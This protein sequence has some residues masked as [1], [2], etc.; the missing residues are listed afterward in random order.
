MT[1]GY[2]Y[3]LGHRAHTHPRAPDSA[4]RLEALLAYLEERG[5]LEPLVHLPVEAIPWDWIAAVHSYD[6]VWAVQRLARQGKQRISFD[7]YL[8][9]YAAEVARLGASSAVWATK[10]VL[11]GRVTNA[12]SLMRPCGHHALPTRAMGYCIFNNVAVAASYA[13]REHGLQRVMVLDIDA[14]HGNGTEAIFYGRRDVLFL[15]THQQPWFPGTGDWHRCGEE[16]GVGYNYNVEMPQWSGDESY[17]KVL[18]QL[19]APLAER[20]RPQLILVSAGFDAHWMD[21]SSV[22]GLSVQ[23][24]AQLVSGFRELAERYCQGRLVLVLEGGYNRQAFHACVAGALR[25]LRGAPLLDDPLGPCPDP[26]VAA[27]DGSLALLRGFMEMIAPP[28][29]PDYYEQPVQVPYE[30]H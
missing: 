25:A 2:V 20:Y 11:E 14:H 18:Q 19:I 28:D 7:T 26:P 10:A 12:F 30:V 23:G 6:H 16:A 5:E 27:V 29:G 9:P 21:H 4:E 17:G 13:L 1:T 3:D 8:S 22:L 15:S 24:Y